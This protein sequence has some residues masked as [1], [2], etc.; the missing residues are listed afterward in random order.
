MIQYTL[1]LGV[2]GRQAAAAVSSLQLLQLLTA[3]SCWQKLGKAMHT[4]GMRRVDAQSGSDPGP[5]PG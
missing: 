5:A 4:W 3:C 2:Q 1:L